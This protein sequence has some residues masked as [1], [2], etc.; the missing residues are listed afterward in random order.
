MDLEFV[1]DENY[2]A[3]FVLSRTM[4]NESNEVKNIKDN[5]FAKN[6]LG[7][8]KILEEELLDLTIYLKEPK[9]RILINEFIS[10]KKFEEI[11][12]LHNNDSKEVIALKILK[13]IINYDDEELEKLKDE[14][15]FKFIDGYHTLL[16]MNSFNPNI[17]L[18]DKDVI[19]IIDEL[20]S[21]SIFK[22]IYKETELYFLNVKTCWEKHKLGINDF[23]KRILKIKFDIKPVVYI[24]HPNAYKGYSFDNN[25]IVWGHYN[26]INDLNYNLVYL[27]HEWLHCLLPFEKNESEIN[28]NIKH[29]VIEL[30]SDYELNSLLKGKSTLNEG[31]SYL[32][33]YKKIV[34]PY[35]LKYI[36]LDEN[37]INKRLEKDSVE[38]CKFSEINLIELSNMNIYEFINF[39]IEKYK[40]SLNDE[41]HHSL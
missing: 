7:H 11:Y 18:E 10:T 35:W 4:F 29:C 13:N 23:L 2:L 15:W 37:Q 40:L 28:A 5:L 20:K 27:V 33:D 8:K 31:H 16:N 38:F 30:I 22:K 1:L 36:G 34:Y 25:K 14:L 41:K 9:I 39:C 3:F 17:F 24:T 26:G 12:Q 32:D 21:T 19:A 6:T